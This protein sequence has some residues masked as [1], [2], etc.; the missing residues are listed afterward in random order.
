MNKK[1]I[2]IDVIESLS[3]VALQRLA[4]FIET[5]RGL[6]GSDIP[7]EIDAAIDRQMAE[8][9][10]DK[11]KLGPGATALVLGCGRGDTLKLFA[12]AGLEVRGVASDR[13]ALERCRSRGFD[14]DLTDTA[15]PDFPEKSASLV[16]A[17]HVLEHSP[18]PLFSLN[19]YA[20]I[21]KNGG[22]AYVEIRLDGDAATPNGHQGWRKLFVRAGFTTLA[23]RNLSITTTENRAATFLSAILR[24]GRGTPADSK[25]ITLALSKGENFGWGVCSKYLKREVSALYPDTEVWDF[26]TDM[27]KAGR[28]GG[29]VVHALTGVDFES[30]TKLRG[31]E[32]YGYTFFENE[33]NE[34][35]VKNAANHDL[36]LGG[37][38]WCREK[39]ERAGIKNS[40]VL[41]Q[42]ID[43]DVFYPIAEDKPDDT[44]V[45]FSGGKFE[46]R[47]GQDLVLKAV[48]ILQKKYDDIVLVNVWR[49]M[50]PQTMKLMSRSGHILFELKGD[51][52]E[53]QM[54]H[55]YDLNGLDAERIRTHGI[56]PNSELRALYAET[57]IGVFPN[58]CEGGTNLVLMEYMA[59]AK[60]VIASYTSGH[61]DILTGE[62]SLRLTDLSKYEIETDGKL[63]AD[64]EEPS[65]DEL[66]GK[67]EYAYHH[68]DE[69]R[70]L[71]RRAGKDMKKRTWKDS[72]REL[73][74]LI[75]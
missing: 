50:W 67:I 15:I 68:R 54:A 56:V 43:P 45:L 58:R 73:L 40:G 5:N 69:I 62:N 39:M 23:M 65:V 3:E 49:N 48:G 74:A 38:T 71:G 34:N 28:V 19:E 44:F 29:K 41:I 14:V 10:L 52:W 4:D 9:F 51:T 32:N 33:L 70:R 36:I 6:A 55:I 26:Q 66:V 53:E 31:T 22:F 59:C 8:M 20:R 72:A 30:I 2:K 42:G 7:P 12:D 37:S 60:P 47:K 57:D 11:H 35:S 61:K 18:F 1:Q 46:L 63:W 75:M 13:T 16:W 17:R 27:A 24:K 21:L 64:W 25:K